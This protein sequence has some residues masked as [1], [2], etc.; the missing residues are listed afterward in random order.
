[1]DAPA[2]PMYGSPKERD[3]ALMVKCKQACTD[4]PLYPVCKRGREGRLMHAFTPGGQ[5]LVSLPA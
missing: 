1:M 4:G 2:P 5:P 3:I